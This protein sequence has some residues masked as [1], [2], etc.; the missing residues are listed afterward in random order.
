[1]SIPTFMP[2]KRKLRNSTF[3]CIQ[4]DMVL[5]FLSIPLVIQKN[6]RKLTTNIE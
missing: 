4:I 6:I 5:D 2:V 1:M 3:F